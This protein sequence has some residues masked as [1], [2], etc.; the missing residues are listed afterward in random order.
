MHVSAGVAAACAEGA[1]LDVTWL[2]A[3]R[4]HGLV[5]IAAMACHLMPFDCFFSQHLLDT[6]MTV[7]GILSLP[8]FRLGLFSDN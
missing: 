1:K 4:Q 3:A 7:A 6:V 2:L 8:I 5:S